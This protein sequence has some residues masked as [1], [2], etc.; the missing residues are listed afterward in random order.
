M[1]PWCLYSEERKKEGR[2]KKE[3][4][5]RL[6]LILILHRHS[7]CSL[8]RAALRPALEAEGGVCALT[9]TQ[10]HSVHEREHFVYQ[11]HMKKT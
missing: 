4:N 1:A 8:H 9:D 11:N 5:T 6:L 3:E 7:W 2:R 10:T